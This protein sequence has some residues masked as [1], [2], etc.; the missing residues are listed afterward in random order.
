MTISQEAGVKLT[1]TKLKKSN[2][3]ARNKSGTI[4]KLNKKIFADEELPHQLFLKTRQTTK[5]RNFFANNMLSN[6][7]LLSNLV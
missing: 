4:L 5:T 2:S 3:A 6:Y 1:N 7:P